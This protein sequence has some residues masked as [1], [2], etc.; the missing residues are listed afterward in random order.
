MAWEHAVLRRVHR[1]ISNQ[2][3]R[4][5]GRPTEWPDEIL[6]N[7]GLGAARDAHFDIMFDDYTLIVDR[8][9]TFLIIWTVICDCIRLYYKMYHGWE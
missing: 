9:L 1:Y 7:Y 8:F 2:Q 3:Q 4:R 6:V 5:Q